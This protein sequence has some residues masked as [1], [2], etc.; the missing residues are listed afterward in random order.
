MEH[1]REYES[2]TLYSPFSYD[3]DTKTGSSIDNLLGEACAF[4][5]D[6]D[7]GDTSSLPSMNS[8][9]GAN[10]QSTVWLIGCQVQVQNFN[11]PRCIFMTSPVI[12][13]LRVVILI[14]YPLYKKGNRA[15][16]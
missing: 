13:V 16:F 10:V 8:P 7:V 12:L 11:N 1:I 4:D 2:G 5:N 15:K 14:L 3:D 6:D 9:F